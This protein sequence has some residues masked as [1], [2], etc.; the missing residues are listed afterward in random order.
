M[1][2]GLGRYVDNHRNIHRSMVLFMTNPMKAGI[3]VAIFF[4]LFSIVVSLPFDN[5]QKTVL[6]FV[7][8]ILF[9]TVFYNEAFQE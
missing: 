7:L 8:V 2:N 3:V 9:I 4:I 1:D 5:I 6:S